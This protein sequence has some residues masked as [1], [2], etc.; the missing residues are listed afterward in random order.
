MQAECANHSLLKMINDVD[1]IGQWGCIGS[2]MG[3]VP[4]MDRGP[5]VH[6]R[7]FGK[8]VQEDFFLFERLASKFAR[9]MELV[10]PSHLGHRL[11]SR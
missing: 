9:F 5:L 1:P 2:T 6:A 8:R 3:T 10:R 7:R 11:G 4:F